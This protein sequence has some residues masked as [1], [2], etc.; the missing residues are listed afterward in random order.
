M[1]VFSHSLF[2]MQRHMRA[3]I[4]QPFYIAFTLVQPIIW[5]VLYGQLFQKV[6]ELPGF[7]A[8]SY[9]DFVTPG[10]VV[11]TAL[12]AGGWNGMG[13]I[14][15]LDGGVMD[16]FLV[17]PVHRSAI[18]AGR[19]TSMALVTVIQSLILIALGFALGARFA[20]GFAGIV[21]LI[22][23]GMLLAFPFGALSNALALTVRKEE[24]VIA[25]SNFLLLPLTFL[26]PVFMAENLMPAWM[27]A[28]SR[29][30]P[31]NWSVEA[32][33]AALSTH[34][35][36]TIVLTRIAYL[37]AFSIA[38]GWVATRAFRAYQRSV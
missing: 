2:M 22:V 7:H 11:M 5:L 38:S 37:A 17:S 33:R 21:V 14:R 34:A 1:S 13:V 26:S 36:W 32:A 12:F 27:R 29:F 6:V 23:T 35:D 10:V 24:S 3:L 15:D 28:V 25:S 18:I 4:R 30:N 9:I 31:V 16:R 19:L 20:G 8:S